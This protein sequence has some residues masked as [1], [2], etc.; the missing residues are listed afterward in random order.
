MTGGTD[1]GS[2]IGTAAT[3]RELGARLIRR[4]R[5]LEVTFARQYPGPILDETKRWLR[6]IARRIAADETAELAKAQRAASRGE[7]PP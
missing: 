7:H 5:E 2:R 4:Q 1:E 6:A 3:D